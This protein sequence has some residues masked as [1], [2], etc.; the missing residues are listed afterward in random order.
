MERQP[1]PATDDLHRLIDA[2]P[3]ERRTQR[4]MAIDDAL[5]CLIERVDLQGPAHLAADLDHVHP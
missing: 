5:P 2:F 1:H 3:H 4:L